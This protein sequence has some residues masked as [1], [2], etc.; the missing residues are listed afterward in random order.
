M[1]EDRFSGKDCG[2]CLN[3]PS[4]KEVKGLDVFLYEMAQNFELFSYIQDQNKK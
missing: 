4:A 2:S 1:F 3:H